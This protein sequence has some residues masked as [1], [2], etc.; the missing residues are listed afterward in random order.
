[1]QQI[2]PSFMVSTQY[3]SLLIVRV[4]LLPHFSRSSTIF[5]PI[6]LILSLMMCLSQRR[7]KIVLQPGGYSLGL[8][9]SNMSRECGQPEVS[10]SMQNFNTWLPLNPLFLGPIFHRSHILC[11]KDLCTNKIPKT[12]MC[13]II[14][15]EGFMSM[16]LSKLFQ[17]S[18]PQTCS[19]GLCRNT[20]ALRL[21]QAYLLSRSFFEA[22][23]WKKRLWSRL[24]GLNQTYVNSW[25]Y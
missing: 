18:V 1:M 4:I 8:A 21:F 14:L 5:P 15:Y 6:A 3:K 19:H 13:H 2:T 10:P 12:S 23:E 7:L 22:T 20:D 11:S 24:S 9:S 25:S 16:L 17:S